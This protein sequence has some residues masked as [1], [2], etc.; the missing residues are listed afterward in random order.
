MLMYCEN[1]LPIAVVDKVRVFGD[2][3]MDE[4]LVWN[5][6][7]MIIKKSYIGR[8]NNGYILYYRYRTIAPYCDDY[9]TFRWLTSFRTY[10]SSVVKLQ[11]LS[12]GRNGSYVNI[13]YLGCSHQGIPIYPE[14][15]TV[16]NPFRVPSMKPLIIGVW[17]LSVPGVNY[18]WSTANLQSHN[19]F[20]KILPPSCHNIE[21][22]AETLFSGNAYL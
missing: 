18:R 2:M 8:F 14:T 9:S 22:A 1:L 13:G 15:A 19:M 4:K 3:I 6:T 20:V 17:L 12:D 7:E 16:L 11:Q 21:A 10:S 5:P